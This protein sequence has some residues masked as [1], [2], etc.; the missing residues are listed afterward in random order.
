MLQLWLSIL[1][2]LDKEDYGGSFFIKEGYGTVICG[3]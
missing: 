1:I 2:G 3:T